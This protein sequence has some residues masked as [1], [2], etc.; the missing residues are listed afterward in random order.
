[1][2]YKAR[3]GRPRR[4]VEP[5]THSCSLGLLLR[6]KSLEEAHRDSNLMKLMSGIMSITNAQGIQLKMDTLSPQENRLLDGEAPHLPSMIGNRECQALIVDGDHNE[7]D[8]DF[9]S[10]RLPVIS[11]GR[12]YP[13]LSIDAVVADNVHGIERLV[14]HLVEFGHRHLAWVGP[15]YSCSFSEDRKTGFIKGCLAHD[16]DFDRRS[17]FG[18]EIYR[19]ESPALGIHDIRHPELLLK[20]MSE[21]VTA[22]VCGNDSVAYAVI[23]ALE[24]NGKRVP[25]D[26][27][28][29]GFDAS[30]PSVPGSWNWRNLTGFDPEF[31]EIGKTAA[32]LA[33]QRLVYP[34]DKT[35][36][37]S[38]RGELVLGDSIARSN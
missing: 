17:I 15:H 13:T 32:R 16:L 20:A 6:N 25:E 3:R 11:I 33:L 28:V 8:L 23:A 19:G 22:F 7:A 37:L 18:R 34:N 26:A 31:F 9:L 30:Y 10:R 14:G 21:G 38:V 4:T 2:G 36:V 29:T 5:N 12:T 24:A 27:S 35:C 1:M